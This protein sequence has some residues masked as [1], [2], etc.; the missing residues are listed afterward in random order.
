MERR[1]R[2]RRRRRGTKSADFRVNDCSRL[3]DGVTR[4]ANELISHSVNC[5]EVYRARR[6]F[7][8]FLAEFQN[9]IVHSS[10][11]GV[12]LISPD[13]IEQFVPA[14]NAVGVSYEELKCL[15]FLRG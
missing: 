4:L 3:V 11:R 5:T 7:L 12:I 15:E 9:V 2:V 8:Q 6:V 1:K 13:F 14:D 10:R